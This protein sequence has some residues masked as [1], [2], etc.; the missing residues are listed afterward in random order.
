MIFCNGDSITFGC[1]LH[2]DD[3][4][5]IEEHR[6]SNIISKKLDKEV[7]NIANIKRTNDSIVSSSIEWIENHEIPEYAIIQFGPD[8]RFEWYDEKKKEWRNISS[9]NVFDRKFFK[10][11]QIEKVPAVPAAIAYFTEVD[12]RHVSQMN[13]WR[14][15]FLLETYLNYKGIPHYFWHG[16]GNPKEENRKLDQLDILYRNLSQ[17]SDMKEMCD[18]I[19]TKNKHPENFPVSHSKMLGLQWGSANGIHPN[20][21]GHKLLAEHLLESFI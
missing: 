14:N 9:N 13:M 1:E 12:N 5:Y 10:N 16:K 6:F 2:K 8:K 17:W 7:I 18:I 11:N 15:V 20:E 4:E 3:I 19:G 21:N